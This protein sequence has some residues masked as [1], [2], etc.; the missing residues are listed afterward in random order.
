MG[1]RERERREGTIGT[2]LAKNFNGFLSLYFNTFYNNV[3]VVQAWPEGQRVPG[4]CH[5]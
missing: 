3:V 2:R 1:G 5:Y 4:S